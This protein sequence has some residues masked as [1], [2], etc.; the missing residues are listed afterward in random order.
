V[1]GGRAFHPKAAA[2]RARHLDDLARA[3]AVGLCPEEV[4]HELDVTLDV[5]HRRIQ[6]LT[7]RE[8]AFVKQQTW[9]RT[10]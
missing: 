5:V 1:A 9:G 3:I 7:A 10:A 4:A 8:R 6:Q 2:A